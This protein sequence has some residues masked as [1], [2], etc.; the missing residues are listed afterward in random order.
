MRLRDPRPLLDRVGL[1]LA[2]IFLGCFLKHSFRVYLCEALLIHTILFWSRIPRLIN[3]HVLQLLCGCPFFLLVKKVPFLKE[4]VCLLLWLLNLAIPIPPWRGPL[5]FLL[6]LVLVIHK[7]L[8]LVWFCLILKRVRLLI[9]LY[10]LGV[11]IQDPVWGNMGK[12]PRSRVFIICWL[13][14]C[15]VLR[16]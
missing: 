7:V 6:L 1:L 11:V 12:W 10:N 14:I 8:L 5:L 2:Q 9:H 16:F 4:S 13:L 3:S 15:K